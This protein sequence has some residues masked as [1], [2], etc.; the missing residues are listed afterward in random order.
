MTVSTTSNTGSAAPPEL[1]ALP[2][3]RHGLPR[4]FVEQ[5]Q[6]T[7]TLA[8]MIEAVAERGYAATTVTDCVEAARVSRKTF[9][10]LFAGKEECFTAAYEAGI[11]EIRRRFV[12]EFDVN[13]G[14]E[15]AIEAALAS[16][17]GFLAENPHVARATMVE[18][19]SS[20]PE[21][22]KRHHATIA[23]LTS[24]FAR[25]REP[26]LTEEVIVAG[27]FALISQRILAGRTET[28]PQLLPELVELVR[29]PARATPVLSG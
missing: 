26:S 14:W 23:G 9:Y 1:C 21:L 22:A 27:I 12:A 29:A 24:Y 18:V 17:L 7:R 6:R 15:E 4:D 20:T 8:G 5:N 16:V 11:G 2:R 28:L 3:G 13:R 19:L 25:D 10:E